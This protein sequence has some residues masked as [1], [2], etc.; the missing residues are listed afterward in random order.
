MRG[1]RADENP[2]AAT[3]SV[4]ICT[5]FGWLW[6]APAVPLLRFREILIEAHWSAVIPILVYSSLIGT[7]RYLGRY[8]DLSGATIT[9]MTIVSVLLVP[10]SILLHELGHTFQARREGLS[11]ERITL[12]GLGGV[13]WNRSPRSPGE[14]FRVV[15]AGPLVS[16][17]LALLFGV[18]GWVGGRAGLPSGTVGVVVL[19]SQFNALM[20]AYNL[21]PVVPL[22]GGRLLHAALWRLR[23]PRLASVWSSRVGVVIASIG[24]AFGVIAPFLN[25]LPQL[26]GFNPGLSIMIDGLVLLWLTLSFRSTT[27]LGARAP[28]EARVGDLVEASVPAEAPAPTL[29]IARFLEG[30]SES[31][32]YGTAASEVVED[33]RTV[34]V[35]SRGLARL[36]PEAQR[37]ETVVADVMLRTAHQPTCLGVDRARRLF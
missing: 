19:F 29:T 23:G 20:F 14:S 32:G 18:L 31:G 33:G 26:A 25:I 36:V 8:P 11:G 2:T 35:I 17:L 7:T 16:T 37:T 6:R 4:S 9:A 10:V 22:D 34:G 1:R 13:S 15:A 5:V 30:A 28:R 12:W 21:I 3:G 24:I 27:Q